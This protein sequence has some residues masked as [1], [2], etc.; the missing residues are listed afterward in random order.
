MLLTCMGCVHALMFSACV[1][2]EAVETEQWSPSLAISQEIGTPAETSGHVL[3]TVVQAG[4]WGP[5]L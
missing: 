2:A 5:G 1:Y 3:T 4:D